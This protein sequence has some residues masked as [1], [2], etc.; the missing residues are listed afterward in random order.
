MWALG[1]G[2]GSGKWA[3]CGVEDREF[4]FGFGGF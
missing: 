4:R 3:Y 2:L 1:I